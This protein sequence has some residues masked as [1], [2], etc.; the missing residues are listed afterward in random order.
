VEIVRP[1]C[2]HVYPHLKTFAKS[3]TILFFSLTPANKFKTSLNQISI[4]ASSLLRQ[5]SRGSRAPQR[6]C[7]HG[8][9][10]KLRPA[11]NL[12]T[13]VSERFMCLEQEIQH[14]RN[15]SYS[16]M[17]AINNYRMPLNFLISSPRTC[18]CSTKLWRLI[19][20]A[21][22]NHMEKSNHSGL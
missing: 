19:C 8:S 10:L 20:L 15:L 1:R 12:L 4:E 5:P 9:I 17:G 18:T 6:L 14:G 11:G 21:M 13:R 7:R 3:Q 22:V 2:L 16:S